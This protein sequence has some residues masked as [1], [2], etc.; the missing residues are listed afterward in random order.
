MIQ[1]YSK[2]YVEKLLAALESIAASTCCG[3]C[4]E[5]KKVAQVALSPVQTRQDCADPVAVGNL[6]GWRSAYEK[7]CKYM[8]KNYPAT[9]LTYPYAAAHESLY[10]T[11][12]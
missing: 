6:S 4:Q 2:K 10:M 1:S 7:W 11:A 12:F 8:K 5:A 9:L 3:D